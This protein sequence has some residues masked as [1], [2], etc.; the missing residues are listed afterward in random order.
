MNHIADMARRQTPPL[1]AVDLSG[2]EFCDSSGLNAL[3]RAWK[4]IST[5]NGRLILLR[6]GARPPA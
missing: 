6:P 3:V 2:L 1:V 5:A 4:Q